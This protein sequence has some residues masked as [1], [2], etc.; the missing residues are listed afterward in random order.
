[1]PHTDTPHPAGC[2]CPDCAGGAPTVADQARP[3]D[4]PGPD[5]FDGA[6]SAGSPNPEDLDPEP[7]QLGAAALRAAEAPPA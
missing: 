3:D 7:D 1:M 6:A 2:T 4:R 5:S